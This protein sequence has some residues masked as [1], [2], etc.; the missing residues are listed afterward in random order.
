MY[1]LVSE[2]ED[3]RFIHKYKPNYLKNN[4]Q[5]VGINN[6]SNFLYERALCAL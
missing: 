4:I 5:E 1:I 6:E 2:K 3:N